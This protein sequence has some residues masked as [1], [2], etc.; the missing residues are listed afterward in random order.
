MFYAYI[1]QS[2][3]H[4]DRFYHGC[5]ADLKRRLSDHNAARSPHSAKFIP[6]KLRF[7]YSGE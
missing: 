3:T 2:L 4:P 5:S 1:L 6:W 7:L